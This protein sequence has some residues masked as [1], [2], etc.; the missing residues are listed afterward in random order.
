MSHHASLKKNEEIAIR[1]LASVIPIGVTR[2]KSSK[3]PIKNSTG[4]VKKELP[5]F[6]TKPIFKAKDHDP[7]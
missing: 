5:L 7:L 2:E 4:K 1:P 6:Y 3:Q